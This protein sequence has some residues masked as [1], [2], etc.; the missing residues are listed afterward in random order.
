MSYARTDMP[1]PMQLRMKIHGLLGHVQFVR[2]R[3]HVRLVGWV[4]QGPMEVFLD[5]LEAR[6]SRRNPNRRVDP[7]HAFIQRELT[8]AVLSIEFEHVAGHERPVICDS[9]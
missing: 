9:R 2:H 6:V 3:V 7:A 4:L 8:R 1:H 5:D